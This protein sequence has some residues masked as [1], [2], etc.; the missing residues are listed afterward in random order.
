MKSLIVA[1]WLKM[2]CPRCSLQPCKNGK[3]FKTIFETLAAL[4]PCHVAIIGEVVYTKSMIFEVFCQYL[5]E[6]LIF[7]REILLL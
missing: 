1:M 2:M 4:G 5:D 3:T 6:F 7:L